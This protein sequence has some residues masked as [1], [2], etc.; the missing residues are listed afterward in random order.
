MQRKHDE[1]KRKPQKLTLIR[2]AWKYAVVFKRVATQS[3]RR[4]ERIQYLRGRDF[5][6][7][8]IYR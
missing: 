5:S 4:L 1:R 7:E 6:Q 8:C 2:R 3:V